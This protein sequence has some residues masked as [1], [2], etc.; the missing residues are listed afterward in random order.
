MK[1]SAANC[2]PSKHSALKAQ[3]RLDEIVHQVMG[4]LVI[5][6]RRRI[7]TLLALSR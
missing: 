1:T 4:N 3:L 7:L 6:P 2:S 5:V